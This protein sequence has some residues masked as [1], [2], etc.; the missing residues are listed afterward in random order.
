MSQFPVAAAPPLV[1]IHPHSL[2]S[3]GDLLAAGG[4]SA[5]ENA[6]SLAYPG[7]NRAILVPFTVL[8]GPITV[9]KLFALNGATASGNIDV[10]LYDSAFTRIVS[11][12]STAQAGTNAM[13]EFD[14][15]DTVLGAGR[16]YLAVAMDNTT[17]TLFRSTFASGSRMMFTGCAQM[18]AAFPLPATITP[19]SVSVSNYIPIVGLTTRTVL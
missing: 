19:A 14:I 12:G 9:V 5:L 1:T 17:G 7:A 15:A 10:G 8:A 6:V 13:Q 18:A 2:E 16:F 3:L 4:G 11:A